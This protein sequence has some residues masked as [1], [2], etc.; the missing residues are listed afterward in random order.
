MKRALGVAAL[1]VASC[2][3]GALAWS[4]VRTAE[5]PHARPADSRRELRYM[6]VPSLTDLQVRMT[7]TQAVQ[8]TEVGDYVQA[9]ARAEL[10]A[11]LASLYT[12]PTPAPAYRAPA[13]QWSS[14]GL[15]N[16]GG[17]LP[18]CFVKFRESRGDYSA[19]N[20]TSSASGAWQ[21]LDSTWNGF[22]GYARAID[23]PPAVQ[24]EAARQLWNGGAGCSHWSACG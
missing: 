12:P 15:G 19:Q 20:P 23:A 6:S 13:P 16:C 7:Y 21:F 24:D 8:A 1:I 5:P 22:G 14:E 3:I 18:P 10:D 11:F 17:D 4:A 9:V 2:V